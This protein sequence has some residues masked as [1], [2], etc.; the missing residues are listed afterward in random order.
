MQT[1]AFLVKNV[2][3]R[4]SLIVERGLTDLESVEAREMALEG[5]KVMLR[6]TQTNCADA[7][8]DSEKT[9]CG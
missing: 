5:D 1:S 6:P 3:K 2:L 8:T 4:R 7:S 9:E